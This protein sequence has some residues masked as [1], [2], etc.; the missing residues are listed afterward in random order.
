MP[1]R[2][3]SVEPPSKLFLDEANGALRGTTLVRGKPVWD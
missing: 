3:E 1:D 2:A